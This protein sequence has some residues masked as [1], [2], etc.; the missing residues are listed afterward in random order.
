M[1]ADDLLHQLG[2]RGL[3][4][5]DLGARVHGGVFQV[6]AA[7][8][9]SG[10]RWA[11]RPVRGWSAQ[12][13]PAGA[14]TPPGRP[15]CEDLPL[16]SGPSK[17]MNMSDDLLPEDAHPA[18]GFFAIGMRDQ[19]GLARHLVL[20]AADRGRRPAAARPSARRS[21]RRRWPPGS[22]GRPCLQPLSSAARPSRLNRSLRNCCIWLMVLA[23]ST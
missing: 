9:G 4:E 22:P 5:Q 16:P 7:P 12:C 6:R 8:R 18:V 2:A 10:R 21:A 14:G 15:I 1:R 17:V 11:C 20:Q 13:S 3:E 23:R 19:V